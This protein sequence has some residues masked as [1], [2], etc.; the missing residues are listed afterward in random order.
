MPT[1]RSTLDYLYHQLP[2]F[3]RM[4]AA[5]FKKNLDNII[6]LCAALEQPQNRF[7]SIHIAGTNG[8]GSTAHLLS[9]VLQ[10][11]GL[12][13]GLYTSPHYR[14]F[15]ERI[16][17]NGQYIGRRAVVRFVEQHRPLFERIQPSFFEITVAMAF[18]YFARQRVDI[19]VIETGLGGRLDSTNILQPLLSVITNISYDHQQFLGDTL[20]AIAGEKAGIIKAKTPVVVGEEQAATKAVFEEKARSV[21]APIHFASRRYQVELLRSNTEH[22]IFQV[23]RAEALY[24]DQL[25]VELHGAYQQKNIAT[26]LMALECIAALP[27]FETWSEDSIRQ[28]WAQLKASTNF[29]GR[30]QYLSHAPRILADSAHNEAGLRMAMNALQKLEYEQLHLVLSVVNDKSIEKV[31]PLFPKNAVY[32]FA[33]ADIPR[34]LAAAILQEKAAAFQLHG[35]TYASVKNA[36]RAAKRRARPEDL[37]YVGGSTFT[38]AEVVP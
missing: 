28:G 16:K 19:G 15:R 3:Q 21:Q 20:P 27:G 7:P 13:V 8:K 33:K 11:K 6:A 36:L 1:Y 37:I 26:A 4:G 2:M 23:K 32:Y 35:R 17:I 9:A 22:S 31:L 24:L 10:A 5:A 29:K 38:V 12:K 34:G 25:V 30:W 18:D 14:D